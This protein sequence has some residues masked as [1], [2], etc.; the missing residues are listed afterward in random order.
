MQQFLESRAA[1]ENEVAARFG[2]LPNFF[3]SARAAPELIEKLWSFAKA[4]YL[5]NPIPALFK[6][7][8]FVLLSRFCPVRYCIVRHVGFLLGHGRAAGD[9]QAPPHNIADV[10]RLLKRPLPW[11]RDMSQVYTRLNALPEPL[12]DWPKPETELEDPIF[13]CAAMIFAEPARSE[14]ARLAL[15]RALGAERFEY[16]AGLLAFIRTAHYWTMLHPGIETEDDM[17]SLIRS[18][19]SWRDVGAEPNAGV[20]TAPTPFL[21]SA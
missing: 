5:E 6:E 4:G 14:T 18:I 13:A 11:T 21:R 3:R 8:L 9:A 17:R 10:I 16:L 20:P 15:L 1:F 2:I 7:R 12:A 19:L